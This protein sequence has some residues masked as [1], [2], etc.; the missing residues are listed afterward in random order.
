MYIA[1]GDNPSMQLS[2]GVVRALIAKNKYGFVNGE[3]KKP[4]EKS[5][6]LQKWIRCDYLVS[7]WFLNSMKDDIAACFGYAYS[8]KV[9]WDDIKERFSEKNGPIYFELGKELYNT[10]QGNMSITDYFGKLKRIWEDIQELD[11]VPEC[12]CGA[13]KTCSSNLLKRILYSDNK[14]KLVQFL[15][16]VDPA[17]EVI[18]QNLLT[19]DPLPS[20]NQAF[21][22]LV[23][24][25]RQR[26]I[27]SSIHP[28]EDS[29]A[30]AASRG[31]QQFYASGKSSRPIDDQTRGSYRKDFRDA[32]KQK[33]LFCRY[34]K[35]EG[36]EIEFCSRLKNR[37]KRSEYPGH[38]NNNR[39]ASNVEGEVLLDHPLGQED[40]PTNKI[41]DNFL[42]AVA[43]KVLQL[44]N[45]R[46]QPADTSTTAHLT[47]FAGINIHALTADNAHISEQGA[48]W[49]VDSGA[50]DHMSPWLSDHSTRKV[51]AKGAR[52]CGLFKIYNR[53]QNL[54]NA[55]F[56]NDDS[57]TVLRA[58]VVDFSS[59]LN[60]FTVNEISQIR[61][62]HYRL[63]HC[64]LSKI[65]LLVPCIGMT[66]LECEICVQAKHHQLPFP[67][68]ISHAPSIFDLVHIDLWGPYKTPNISRAVYFLTLVDDHSR[69]TWT[70]LLKDKLSDNG[71]EI[72]Q[73]GCSSLFAQK[74]IVQQTSIPRV[75]QQN[76]R[77]ERKHRHLV[78]TA[79]AIRLHANFPKKFWGE[80]I[81]AATYIIN[82]LP[83]SVLQWKVPYEV[84]MKKKADYSH[85]R[86]I[87]CLA[88]S[89]D[90]TC[91]DKFASKAT[92]CV[93]IGYPQASKGYKLF[94]L[95]NNKVMFSRD[96]VFHES[97]FPFIEQV[98][99]QSNLPL[100]TLSDDSAVPDPGADLH[101]PAESTDDSAVLPRDD[102]PIISNT[103]VPA[104][105]STRPR[106]LST[107]L[108]GYTTPRLSV[109]PS[110]TPLIAASLISCDFNSYSAD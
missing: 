32:K 49:I 73:S 31:S 103:S 11:G 102:P 51:L 54:C 65:Q 93:L 110:S 85:L 91:R 98:I 86:V 47:N 78:E 99:P 19:M 56:N 106:I 63:G 6:N 37:N 76:G 2:R 97:T 21:S 70:H 27:N 104:R 40:Q 82:L 107:R 109:I 94:D 23:Q 48:S 105:H 61:L 18:N 95:D 39:F 44:Q 8:S 75:P 71:T 41:D 62:Q 74:G 34:C 89:L 80:C 36:H 4:A 33:T 83:S 77:V 79:R 68:S 72:V 66:K 58:S 67:R 100:V 42:L 59:D 43:Q 15:M 12:T 101:V 25:E 22:R 29:S 30:L 7:S 81:L 64:S 53:Q 46:P 88:F 57:S 96:V 9:L 50:T 35:K 14:R 24:A 3:I 90:R 45:V 108:H 38:Y 5:P 16:G 87:G 69:A 10:Q 92:R 17:Y 26:K 20:I 60:V 28:T 13:V 52:S 84:L 55:A 1:S